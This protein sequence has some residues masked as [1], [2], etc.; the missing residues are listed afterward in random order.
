[1]F[2]FLTAVSEKLIRLLPREKVF[3][4]LDALRLA[5]HLWP[6]AATES[7]AKST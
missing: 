1:M 4:A 2:L 6:K 5:L 7:F 3:P